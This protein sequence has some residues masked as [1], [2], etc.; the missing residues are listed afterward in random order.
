MQHN[1]AKGRAF[2]RIPDDE[3]LVLAPG[4]GQSAITGQSHASYITQMT[5]ESM[6]I[7]S[8]IDVPDNQIGI[9]RAGYDYGFVEHCDCYASHVIGVT[10]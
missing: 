7:S 5:R 3:A 6:Q 10:N 2:L 1:G 4:N 9:S 8:G